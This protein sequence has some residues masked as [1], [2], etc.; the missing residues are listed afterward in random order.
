MRNAYKISD[1]PELSFFYDYVLIRAQAFVDGP[2]QPF[3]L[4][5]PAVIPHRTSYMFNMELLTENFKRVAHKYRPRI[6]PYTLWNPIL[7]HIVF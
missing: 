6:R 3:D 2:D 7:C 1:N 5:V 4:A